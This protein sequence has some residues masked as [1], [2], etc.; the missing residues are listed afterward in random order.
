[1]KVTNHCCPDEVVT[2]DGPQTVVWVY[3]VE[4]NKTRCCFARIHT[5]QDR[6]KTSILE[7]IWENKYFI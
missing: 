1:M 3:M 2:L 7:N 4:G 5:S 6:E